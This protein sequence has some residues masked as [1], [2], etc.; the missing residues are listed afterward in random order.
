MS[1]ESHDHSSTA[2]RQISSLV[3][4]IEN[5]LH[6]ES[7]SCSPP[8]PRHVQ[9]LL[10]ER[11]RL[12][13]HV[14]WYGVKRLLAPSSDWYRNKVLQYC[15][16][17]AGSEHIILREKHVSPQAYR[18][19]RSTLMTVLTKLRVWA[20]VEGQ[21]EA[22]TAPPGS[23]QYHTHREGWRT[24]MLATLQPLYSSVDEPL[25]SEYEQL[26]LLPPELWKRLQEDLGPLKGCK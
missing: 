6:I 21:V 24:Q 20:V 22:P 25:R 2:G 14:Q 11:H 10:S 23:S 12:P 16:G 18:V 8:P 4:E 17:H 1:K 9:Q 19:W 7:K 3:D 13:E 5:A 15:P 26:D